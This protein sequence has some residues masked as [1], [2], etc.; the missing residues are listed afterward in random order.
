MGGKRARDA[1]ETEGTLGLVLVEARGA[2]AAGFGRKRG[3]GAEAHAG[4]A[5]WDL[6]GAAVLVLPD[7]AI[8]TP[9]WLLGGGRHANLLACG[10]A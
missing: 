5:T 6:V 9:L 2:V 10:A 3:V 8:V 7:R 1:R 4:I